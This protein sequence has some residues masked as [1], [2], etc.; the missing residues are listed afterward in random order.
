VDQHDIRWIIRRILLSVFLLSLI[1]GTGAFYFVLHDREIRQ[2]E[3]QA[4]TL[5]SSAFAVRGYTT[6]HILPLLAKLPQ[7]EFY[8]ETVPSFAA[9]T[10]FH[11]VTGQASG[12]SYREPALNPT[13][14]TDRP[15]AFEVDLIRQFRDRDGLTE[16][17]GVRDS[18]Q[19][20][21]FYLARPIRIT[22]EACLGCH[23]TPERAPP[24]MLARYGSANGFGWT[25]NEVIGIQ[26]L[27]VPVTRQ[28]TGTLRLVMYLAGGL[29][30]M[31][32]VCYAVLSV[33]L[34][35]MVA[36]PLQALARAADAASLTAGHDVRLPMAGVRELQRLAAA[37]E[38]LR[39]SLAKTMARLA[40]DER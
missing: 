36:R 20:R 19:D 35:A 32:V 3:E 27:T 37:I 22:S 6:Q 9:Q 30:L 16:L 5:L 12:Y 26:L 38:R 1:V 11:S 21:L 2:A 39:V 34:D 33:A 17:T 24:T 31:F 14:V 4:R 8:E 18:G 25:M 23:S 13:S 28:F 7:N 15:S 29:L 10:V 40:Q